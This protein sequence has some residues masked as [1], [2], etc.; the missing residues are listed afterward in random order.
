MAWCKPSIIQEIPAG[1]VAHLVERSLSNQ[2]AHGAPQWYRPHKLAC[3]RY[4]FDS[5]LLHLILVPWILAPAPSFD[6]IVACGCTKL[7]NA[8]V[9]TQSQHKHTGSCGQAGHRV[10]R[11]E[12]WLAAAD[13]QALLEPTARTDLLSSL[14]QAV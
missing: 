7:R 9:L 6:C 3:E 8:G 1:D 10:G 12:A 11:E 5:L 13:A 14:Q 4:G 2:M